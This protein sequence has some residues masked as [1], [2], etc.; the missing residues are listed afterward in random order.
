VVLFVAFG[1]YAQMTLIEEQEKLRLESIANA[2]KDKLEQEKQFALALAN[3]YASL[4]QV[5]K[6]FADKDRESLIDQLMNSYTVIAENYGIVQ[7]QFHVPPAT[8]FLRLH[9]IKKYGDDLSSFRKTVVIANQ[10]RKEVAGL[11]KG[12]GGLGI[13]GVVPVYYQNEFVGTFEIGANF[14][15]K[16]FSGLKKSH[17]ADFSFYLY[18]HQSKVESFAE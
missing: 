3:A 12:K 1:L 18:E 2:L 17:Q 16:F 11:E 15:K 13:R 8:S 14:D 10:E 9:D 5:Q 6:S 7:G 4:P